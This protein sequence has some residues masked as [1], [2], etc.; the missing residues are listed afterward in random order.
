MPPEPVE[1]PVPADFVDTFFVNGTGVSMAVAI[2]E[3]FEVGTVI[4]CHESIAVTQPNHLSMMRIPEISAPNTASP[5]SAIN[6]TPIS[7][8][9]RA[10]NGAINSAMNTTPNTTPNNSPNSAQCYTH[11]CSDCCPQ[12]C[13]SATKRK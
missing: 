9:N 3:P 10:I 13:N 12:Y 6:T 11:N 5:I 4:E 7:A 1:A 2:A 8:P